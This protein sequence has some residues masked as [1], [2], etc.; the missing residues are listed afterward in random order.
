MVKA[1][2]FDIFGFFGF[3]TLFIVGMSVREIVKTEAIIIIT[4]SLIGLV[5]DG[6][7]VLTKFI[8]K[9][10]RNKK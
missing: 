4:I 5:V 10:K 3:L 8:L 6:Y 9:K 1:E 2:F 7:I